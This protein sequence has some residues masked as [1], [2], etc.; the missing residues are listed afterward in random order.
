MLRILNDNY[1]SKFKSHVY[2]RSS[3]ISKTCR[4]FIQADNFFLAV[5]L[6]TMYYS[7]VLFHMMYRVEIYFDAPDNILERINILQ[8]KL[9]C[10]ID[11][12]SY[13]NHAGQHFKSVSLLKVNDINVFSMSTRVSKSIRKQA[14]RTPSELHGYN[15]R[16]KDNPNLKLLI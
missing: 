2:Q 7:L 14:F 13:Y 8:K 15:T 10:S 3:K 12:P 9:I 5:F 11:S 4:T 6:K 1:H 16:I